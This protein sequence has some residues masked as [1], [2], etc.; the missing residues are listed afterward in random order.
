MARALDVDP[1]HEPDV[2]N[3]VDDTSEV[4]DDVDALEQRLQLGAGDVDAGELDYTRAALGLADVESEHALDVGVRG[5][6][7]QQRTPHEAGCAGDRNGMHPH[8]LTAWPI[9]LNLETQKSPRTHPFPAFRASCSAARA[10]PVPR[11]PRA[12]RVAG[13]TRPRSTSR[14]SISAR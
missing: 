3:G 4:H 10:D 5:E 9:R 14:R 6:H 2:G 1:G 13:S 12:N 8:T 7:R 11:V